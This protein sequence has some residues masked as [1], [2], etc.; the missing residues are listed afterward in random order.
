MLTPPQHW[1]Q[2]RRNSATSLAGALLDGWYIRRS[3]TMGNGS[4]V[5]RWGHLSSERSDLPVA[6]VL[7]TARNLSPDSQ[8]S[9]FS[10]HYPAFVRTRT[11]DW[12]RFSISLCSWWLIVP[13]H[14][15]MRLGMS[16]S[17]NKVILWL[18]WIFCKEF[19][20][21]LKLF[22]KDAGDPCSKY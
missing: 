1:V 13:A 11:S 19:W 20:T 10:P 2:Q 4:G 12:N 22:E 8:V 9:C 18:L 21:F 17:F 14:S 15:L 6:E 16:V 3:V 7:W 5:D